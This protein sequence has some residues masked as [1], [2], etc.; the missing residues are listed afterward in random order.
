MRKYWAVLLPIT[1]LALAGCKVGLDTNTF[2]D[3]STVSA[4]IDHVDI[5]SDS[6]S[7]TVE[8][9]GGS[10][11]VRRHVQYG[12]TK[13]GSTTSVSG[14]TLRLNGCG[15]GCSVDYQVRVPAG[16]Y[17]TGSAASG[18][19]QL[20]GVASVDVHADSGSV[21]VQHV[22]G[23]VRAVTESGSVDVGDVRGG[24]DVSADSGDVHVSTS[25][26]CD[27]SAR[28]SSG[29]VHVDVAAGAYRVSTESG[30]GHA[31]VAVPNSPSAAHSLR[32]STDSGSIDVGSH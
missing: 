19:L 25:A 9:G 4:A 8:V 7:V 15:D 16:T 6:G 24:V 30:D 21:R 12:D 2:S 10:T 27:V 3:E 28:T 5:D 29:S 17:V 32:V 11:T 20:D 22:D 26:P 18:S 1:A 13:P 23:R 31:K 14:R